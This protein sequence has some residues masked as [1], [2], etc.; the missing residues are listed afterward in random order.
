MKPWWSAEQV[1]STKVLSSAADCFGLQHGCRYEVRMAV[2]CHTD[3][4]TRWTLVQAVGVQKRDA[5]PITGLDAL[6]STLIER[7]VLHMSPVRTTRRQALRFLSFAAVGGAIA[8]TAPSPLITIARAQPQSPSQSPSPE[9]HPLLQ[10]LGEQI[11]QLMRELAVPGVAVGV[12]LEGQDHSAGFGV[13]NIEYPQTVD[14]RTIFQVGSITKTFT[15]TAAAMLAER[16]LVDLDAPIRSYVPE[17]SLVDTDAA[18]RITLRHV[19]SHSSG[20]TDNALPNLIRND[21][22]LA[23][24]V[25]QLATVPQFAPPGREFSYSNL[26][27]CLEGRVVEVAGGKP[28]RDLISSLILRP[29]GL[30]RSSYFIEDIV[31]YPVAAGHV[32]GQGGLRVERPFGS[33]IFSAATAPAGGLF[34]TADELLQWAAFHLGDGRSA[35]GERIA[36]RGTLV[37][38]QQRSGPGGA[39]ESEDLDGLGVNWQ[40]RTLTG[41]RIVQHGGDTATHHSEFL[42]VPDRDFAFVLLTNAPGGSLLRKQLTP[43]I[44]EHFLGL[45]EPSRPGIAIS[46]S[47][48]NEYTGTF[49]TRGVLN[50]LRVFRTGDGIAMQRFN[51]DATLDPNTYGMRLYAPDRAV[52]SG[53]EED[54]N[55]LDF[56]RSEE[57]SVSWVRHNGR[58][59]ERL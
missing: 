9:I 46:D 4:S 59:V 21:D 13:T 58:V 32:P 55:L 29:L 11:Q 42:M 53:G 28:Y 8:A 26:G 31:D 56:L 25:A 33:G 23:Q 43:W 2:A 18:N 36:D 45:R 38:M 50:D 22:G 16:G 52:V 47:G 44:L 14:G 39:M 54:G 6:S 12:R 57:G 15:G 5:T 19:A 37:S 1:G 27:V 41:G 51:L 48:L 30:T 17:L 20:F 34:S 24:A 3:P 35:T 10:E 49:G 40:L 7:L